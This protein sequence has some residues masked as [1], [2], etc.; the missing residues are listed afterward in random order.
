MYLKMG[1]DIVLHLSDARNWQCRSWAFI[2][3]YKSN[4][5]LGS[6]ELN[7]QGSFSDQIVNFVC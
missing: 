5:E 1:I 6:P 3:L 2:L 4:Y 7:T